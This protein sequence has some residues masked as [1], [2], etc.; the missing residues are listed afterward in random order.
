LTV[1]RDGGLVEVAVERT[2]R[3]KVEAKRKAATES[4]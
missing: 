3:T 4:E 1:S 2:P